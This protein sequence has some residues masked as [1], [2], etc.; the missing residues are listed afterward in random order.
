MDLYDC[1]LRKWYLGLYFQLNLV[2]GP[3]SAIN[4]VRGPYFNMVKI[5]HLVMPNF[6]HVKIWS[7]GSFFFGPWDN[8]L[9]SI[10]LLDSI[11]VSKFWLDQIYMGEDHF[12]VPKFSP[13]GQNFCKNI[14]PSDH[15]LVWTKF[16]ITLTSAVVWNSCKRNIYKI[17]TADEFGRNWQ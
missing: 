12:Q 1:F 3:I 6:D 16:G 14:D 2:R 5:R 17:L 11:L 7:D 8:I 15:I 10:F 9:A 4:L 13:I